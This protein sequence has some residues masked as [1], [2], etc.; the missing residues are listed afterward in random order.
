MVVVADPKTRI[1]LESKSFDINPESC[2]TQNK[3]LYYIGDQSVTKDGYKC[4]ERNVG[5]GDYCRNPDGDKTIWC[6]TED[7]DKLFG[8]CEPLP[9]TQISDD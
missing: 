7:T 9:T 3:C 8:Y 5:T 2:D 6:Y 1:I 4:K